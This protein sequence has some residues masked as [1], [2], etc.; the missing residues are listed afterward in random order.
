MS[1]VPTKNDRHQDHLQVNIFQKIFSPVFPVQWLH[2]YY[3]IHLKC[4]GVGGVLEFE[5][6]FVEDALRSDMERTFVR[7]DPHLVLNIASSRFNLSS[8]G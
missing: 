5:G 8:I 1:P 4:S 2:N 6:S 3:K 7:C